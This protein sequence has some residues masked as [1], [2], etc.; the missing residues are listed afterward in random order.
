MK[1]FA[2]IIFSVS[3]LLTGCG[4][5][6]GAGV[7]PNNSAVSADST[8]MSLENV[9][10]LMVAPAGL[11]ADSVAFNKSNLIK[12]LYAALGISDAQAI[13]TVSNQVYTIGPKGEISTSNVADIIVGKSKADIITGNS[14]SASSNWVMRT[15]K[16]IIISYKDLFKPSQDGK[17]S[18]QCNL[19]G[20]RISDGLLSC[21]NINP[22]CDSVNACDITNFLSQIKVDLSGEV[23]FM[24][25]GDGGLYKVDL[26]NPLTPSVSTIFTSKEVGNAQNPVVNSNGDVFVSINMA[27]SATNVQTRIY[28]SSGKITYIADP[29]SPDRELNDQQINCAFTGSNPHPASFYYLSIEKNNPIPANARATLYEMLSNGD[30][31]FKKVK[32]NSSPLAPEEPLTLGYTNC[33]AVVS[34]PERAFAI[35]YKIQGNIPNRLYELSNLTNEP[36]IYTLNNDFD[37]VVAMKG[38]AT[39]LTILGINSAHT[40]NG[41]DRFNGSSSVVTNVLPIGQY[42]IE[43]MTIS[44]NCTITFIGKRLASKQ[45]IIGTIS[46]TNVLVLNALSSGPTSIATLK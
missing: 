40:S 36:K 46:P 12:A 35:G 41:I 43:S 14:T 27:G 13:S 1:F 31:T 39:G 19:V 10:Q 28:S 42:S 7:D 45:N 32:I 9:S 8:T 33:A 44:N 4:G 5:G 34:Q 37:S 2:G 25:A 16:F 30:G 6:G 17:S 38:C 22:R 21:I 20:I 29:L 26:A 15:P 24:V 11:T 23:F 18:Q 3:L